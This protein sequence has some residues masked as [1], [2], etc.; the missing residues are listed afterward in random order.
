MYTA[1]NIDKMQYLITYK[2]S[3][4]SLLALRGS[5]WGHI[6]VHR[7]AHND[8]L[9]QGYSTLTTITFN[10]FSA[11]FSNFWFR[12][13]YENY[14]ADAWD[15]DENIKMVRWNLFFNIFDCFWMPHQLV[16]FH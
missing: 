16:F 10:G 13:R 3:R 11:I 2:L 1:T 5:I 12:Q 14:F 8:S 6:Y 7:H 15:Y 4:Y 9:A